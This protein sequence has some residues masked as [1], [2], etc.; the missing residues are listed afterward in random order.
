[1]LGVIDCKTKKLFKTKLGSDVRDVC[2]DTAIFPEI[3]P[4]GNL[5]V[6]GPHP[7]ERRWYAHIVVEDYVIKQIN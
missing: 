1:M 7:H 6:V 3:K 5:Y 4:N 2:F